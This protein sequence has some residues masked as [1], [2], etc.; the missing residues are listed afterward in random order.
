MYKLQ[1]ALIPAVALG[2]VAAG[3]GGSGGE[4]AQAPAPPSQA[5]N[6]WAQGNL[7]VETQGIGDLKTVVFSSPVGWGFG[8]LGFY[9][10]AITRFE[11]RPLPGRIAFCRM[12]SGFYQ[13]FVADP[14]GGREKQI[15]NKPLSCSCPRFSPD[16]TKIVYYTTDG[17]VYVVNVDGSGDHLVQTFTTWSNYT[18]CWLLDG[19][20]L[21]SGWNGTRRDI[22]R[23]SP[24]GSGLQQLTNTSEHEYGPDCSRDGSWIAYYRPDATDA[25][26]WV[27]RSDGSEQRQLTDNSANDYFPRWSPDGSSIVFWS[28]RDGNYELYKMEP[29]G[30]NQIRL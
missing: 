8:G 19:T 11:Y 7:R 27:M 24:Y 14:D 30:S 21:F 28:D 4:Q 26:I 2:I 18:P 12:V 13:I 6:V 3:C 9:G 5:A 10:T 23:A 17:R 22:Y 25:E 1:L 20:V 16:G 15:T 29:D